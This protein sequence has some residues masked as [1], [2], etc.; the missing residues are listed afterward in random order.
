MQVK[1]GQLGQEEL[2]ENNCPSAESI[3]EWQPESADY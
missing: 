1:L 3:F 2:N